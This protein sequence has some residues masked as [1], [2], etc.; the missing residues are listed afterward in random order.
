[1]ENIVVAIGDHHG[2]I[3]HTEWIHSP[4]SRVNLARF[5]MQ[6]PWDDDACDI[7]V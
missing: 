5:H 4:E 2:S 7:T 6:S 3:T 1:M